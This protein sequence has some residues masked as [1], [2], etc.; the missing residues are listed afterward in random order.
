M[1]LPIHYARLDSTISEATVNNAAVLA[2][3]VKRRVIK[4]STKTHEAQIIAT[5]KKSVSIKTGVQ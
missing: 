1:I 2:A 5:V 4:T 3:T